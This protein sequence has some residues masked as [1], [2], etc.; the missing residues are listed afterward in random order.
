MDRERPMWESR[1]NLPYQH[2]TTAFLEVMQSQ[3]SAASMMV[4]TRFSAG[5]NPSLAK[6]FA[7]SLEKKNVAEVATCRRD[8]KKPSIDWGSLQRFLPISKQYYKHTFFN[9]TQKL[10]NRCTNNIK[11]FFFVCF[12]YILWMFTMRTERG[13]IWTW[14][15]E[16]RKIIPT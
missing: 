16:H 6:D 4:W 10:K 9:I 11:G 1:S 7:L 2:V 13:L 5:K 14:S 15:L 3:F 12:V 8:A